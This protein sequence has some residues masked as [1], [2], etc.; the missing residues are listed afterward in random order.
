[1]KKLTAIAAL[2]TIGW[3]IMSQ[4]T[5]QT[6]D[7]M[8]VSMIV[9]G[10]YVVTMEQGKIIEN[11]AVAVDQGKILAVGT[12][13]DIL[14]QYSA[15]QV[16]SGSGKI[17]MPGLVNG[18]THT[19]M[20]LMRGLADDLKLMDWLT[21]Y[22][23][24]MEG[25]F[26]DP[27]FIKTGS[28][29]ACYEMIRSGTTTFVDMYF[30]PDTIAEVVDQCGM[31]AVITAPMIDFP[32]PGFKGWEDSYQAGVDFAKRWKNKHP[33]ITPGLAPHAPYTVSPEHLKQAADTA[34]ELGVPMSV[35]V[36][37]DKSETKTIGEKYGKTPVSHVA[38]QG[39]FNVP[40]QVIA[41]HVVWPTN[42]EIKA[43][44][45]KPFGPIHNPTSNMKLAAGLS[46]VPDM[47]K[48]GVHVGLGTD[49]AAS[50][51]DLDMWGEIHLAALLHKNAADDPTVMPAYDAVSL[52]TN[53]GA[54]AIGK[55]AEIGSLK[56]GKFADMI[57][58]DISKLEMQPLYNV[59]S[60]LAYTASGADVVTTIVHGKVLMQ[61]RKVL[62]INSADLKARVTA[63]ANAIKAAIDKKKDEK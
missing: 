60:H 51:N 29:L 47:I 42:D 6:G 18:H 8:T 26:V 27:D 23:F 22:I 5:D 59:M 36:A 54:H 35:H 10:D 1:M 57:Q 9:R 61:D 62:T 17:L 52:A 45:G 14:K 63:K 13:E 2:L 50:N 34:R 33:R 41:A 39:Y 19:S 3:T 30:Y 4:A 53:S 31:R 37:E 11:G 55:G 12:A 56:A 16:I 38:D 48:A 46:P 32:S 40:E 20:T 43:M 58:I 15:D 25:Q 24:P 21:G 44:V 28:E 49:G 7:Q